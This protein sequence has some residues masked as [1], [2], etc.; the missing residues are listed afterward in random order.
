MFEIGVSGVSTSHLQ[1]ELFHV[2]GAVVIF[3]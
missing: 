1:E 3:I 2:A